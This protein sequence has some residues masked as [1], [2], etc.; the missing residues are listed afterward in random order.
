MVVTADIPA[1][2]QPHVEQEGPV[3][4]AGWLDL[5]KQYFGT[6]CGIEMASASKAEEHQTKRG[7]FFF[8]P[9]ETDFGDNGQGSYW[10]NVSWSR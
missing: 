8:D 4:A 3:P 2:V 5:L 9:G 7:K 6:I 10:R 1:H